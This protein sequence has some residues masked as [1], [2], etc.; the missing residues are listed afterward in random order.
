MCDTFLFRSKKNGFEL[1]VFGVNLSDAR[2]FAK[3]TH[4]AYEMSYVSKNPTPVN[5]NMVFATTDKQMEL[6]RKKFEE[7]MN[8]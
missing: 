2:N 7:F 1:L 8:A 5:K 4:S 3:S 6:N